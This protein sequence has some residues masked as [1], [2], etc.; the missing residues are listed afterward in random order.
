MR[1][2]VRNKVS[3]VVSLEDI[4]QFTFWNLSDIEGNPEV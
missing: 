4:E 1:R 2:L 3:L